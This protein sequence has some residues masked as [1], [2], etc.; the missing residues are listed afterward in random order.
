MANN[1]FERCFRHTNYTYDEILAQI[2][3]LKESYDYV[4]YVSKKDRF[5]VWI[6][7]QPT[8]ESMIY[9]VKFVCAVNSRKVVIFVINPAI[10]RRMKGKLVPHMYS[11]GSLCLYYPKHKEWSIEDDWGTTLVPWTTLWLFYY[12]IWLETGEW[13]GGGKHPR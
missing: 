8:S 2:L 9:T 7:L 11:D 12:E 3:K 4:E 6:K 10:K 1:S 13:L 5:T